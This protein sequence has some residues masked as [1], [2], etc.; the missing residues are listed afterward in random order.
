MTSSF[1]DYFLALSQD[2][3]LSEQGNVSEIGR[4]LEE[5]YYTYSTFSIMPDNIE[6]KNPAA[7]Y[8]VLYM[9]LIFIVNSI[10]AETS[11]VTSQLIRQIDVA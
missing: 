6:N 3:L 11:V 7:S 9:I 8:R 1:I 5:D 4:V 2:S 10:L